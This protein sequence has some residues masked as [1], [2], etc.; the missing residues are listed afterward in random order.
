MTFLTRIFSG[1]GRAARLRRLYDRVVAEGR[2]PDWYRA[3]AVADTVDGR[4][5]MI[6]ALLSVA[7]WRLDALGPAGQS[8]SVRLT[9]IFIDDMDGS[10]RQLGIGDLVVGKH[11]GRMVSALGGRLGAYRAE[12]GAE[13]EAAV[14]RNIFRGAPP[15]AEAVAYVARGIEQ[16]RRTLAM[17]DLEQLVAGDWQ[18]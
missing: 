17:L 10:V 16:W 4:F 15:G 9:E 1:Q 12:D 11:V 3:G 14:A 2:R 7:L 18:A 5:D 8:A 13:M 6:A